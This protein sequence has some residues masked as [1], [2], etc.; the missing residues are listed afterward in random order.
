[1]NEVYLCTKIQKDILVDGNYEKLEWRNIE[2]VSLMEN[3]KGNSPKMT[4]MVKSIWSDKYL[5]FLFVCKDDFIKATMTSFN[6]KLYEEDVV[7]IFLDDN[8]DIK[9]YIE[10][11]INPLNAVLHYQVNNNLKGDILTYARVDN[12]IQSAVR[13]NNSASEISYEIAIPF[14]EFVTSFNTPP[15]SGDSWGMNLF[16][17]DRGEDTEDEY[18]AWSPTGV[19]NFHKPEFFGKINFINT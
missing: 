18:S 9:T 19:L 1:M 11:E 7:E 15:K 17:I 10:I 14:T 4:T 12:C 8:N 2:E 13:I 6:D 5:Y 16:R 3:I